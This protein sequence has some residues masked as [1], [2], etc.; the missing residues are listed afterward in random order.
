MNLACSKHWAIVFDFGNRVIKYEIDVEDREG[1]NSVINP[2]WT[3][4]KNVWDQLKN[5]VEIEEIVEIDGTRYSAMQ[6]LG[7]VKTSPSTV[8][9]HAASVS[10][11]GQEYRIVFDNCQEWA[12]ELLEKVDPRLKTAL[13]NANIR[14][15]AEWV[16]IGVGVATGVKVVTCYAK[17]RGGGYER[18]E[19][20]LRR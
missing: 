15:I 10:S 19:E 12:K 11:N 3:D 2:K 6:E 13:G 16:K 9:D 5:R 18:S 20:G 4:I 14:S 7:E 1:G 8:R 17:S